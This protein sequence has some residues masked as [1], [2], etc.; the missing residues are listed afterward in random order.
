VDPED[1]LAELQRLMAER[2]AAAPEPGGDWPGYLEFMAAE[3]RV[4]EFAAAHDAELA[5]LREPTGEL[6]SEQFAERLAGMDAELEWLD[7]HAGDGGPAGEAAAAAW[8]DRQAFAANYDPDAG[9]EAE[10]G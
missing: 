7:A 8:T 2:D 5:A 9:P 4:G 1:A 6:T 3:T 10:A